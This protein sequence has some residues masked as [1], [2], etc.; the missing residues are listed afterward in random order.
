LKNLVELIPKLSL[1][2][3]ALM[4]HLAVTWLWM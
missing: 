1:A 4:F 2:I 3:S